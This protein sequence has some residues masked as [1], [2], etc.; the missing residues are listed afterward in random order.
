MLLLPY[1][2][3]EIEHKI[4][5]YKFHRRITCF[6]EKNKLIIQLELRSSLCL[7]R[8]NDVVFTYSLIRFE[9]VYTF[10]FAYGLLHYQDLT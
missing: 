6:S 10:V 1:R 9:I 2:R 4:M 3:N 8:S 5:L 7:N